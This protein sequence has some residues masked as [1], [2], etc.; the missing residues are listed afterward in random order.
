MPFSA[1]LLILF[2][3]VL[4]ASWNL[5][6]K[7][8]RP[9]IVFYMQAAFTAS[10][11]WLVP[12]ILGFNK[13][14]WA[15]VP[16]EFFYFGA[17]SVAC[18]VLYFIGLANAYKRTDISLAY[19]MARALP[20]LFTAI[21]SIVFSL[22]KPL[23]YWSM[24]GM[25]L[26]FSGCFIMPLKKFSE[27]KWSTYLSLQFIFI[28]LGASGT[29]GYTI[30]DS[31]ALGKLKT[32]FNAADKV[33]ISCMYLGILEFC[34]AIGL[35]CIVPF[36]RDERYELRHTFCRTWVPSL[37]SLFSSSA[38]GIILLAMPMV[39]NVS[40]V[41]A[42]RQI[43]LPLCALAGVILLHEK[44]TLPRTVGLVLFVGGLVLSVY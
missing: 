36:F 21:L 14:N 11:L 40:L 4:H 39:T 10:L 37:A 35:L 8:R 18:E 17:G 27:L 42:F 44:M 12:V 32:C 9:S 29:T 28:I 22:G 24:A 34:I 41:Q 25:A 43:S 31:L 6:S 5:M 23:S 20:V 38:Y 26:I 13:V 3:A 15:G 33:W 19:P 2:S 7:A 16:R 30:C 1:F